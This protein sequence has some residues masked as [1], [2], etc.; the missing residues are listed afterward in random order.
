MGGMSPAPKH[1]AIPARDRW[2]TAG[3]WVVGA[4]AAAMSWTGW[5]L[6][7]VMCGWPKWLAWLLPLAVDVYVVTSARAWLRL[8]W[9]STRTRRYAAASTFLAVL[10]S[11]AAN[12]AYH[13]MESMGMQRAPWGVVVAVSGLAPLMLALVAHLE[14]RLNADRVAFGKP[15]GESTPEAVT[16]A[17]P[18]ATGEPPEA[19]AAEAM[20]E[21]AAE[22]QAT[23]RDE[24]EATPAGEPQTV[25]PQKPR[26]E[27]A[28]L[29]R[30]PEDVKARAAYRRSVAAGKPLSDRALGAMFERGRTWGANR[31]KEC[32][33]GPK[34][35]GAVAK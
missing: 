28:A 17:M 8:P 22:P 7:A 33:G 23:P 6:L 26:Q 19:T 27:P 15:V 4:A 20:E 16:E 34:L 5:F 21:P 24:P 2:T 1:A 12:A 18:Q 10:F 3:I 13:L 29:S 14:A 35:A 25:P 9:V 31:I 30:D 11:V 32:E